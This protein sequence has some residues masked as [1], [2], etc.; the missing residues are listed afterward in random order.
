MIF[1]SIKPVIRQA[2]Y[3]FTLTNVEHNSPSK[4]YRFRDCKLFH[5]SFYSFSPSAI[6][7]THYIS[8]MYRRDTSVT[9]YRLNQVHKPLYSE[10]S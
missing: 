2:L 3:V 4:A 6:I 8:R 5:S 1:S 9:D 7:C 10:I